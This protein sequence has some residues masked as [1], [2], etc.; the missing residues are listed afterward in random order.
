[1]TFYLSYMF[2]AERFTNWC[3]HVSQNAFHKISTKTLLEEYNLMHFYTTFLTK[4]LLSNLVG[5]GEVHL[6]S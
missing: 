3:S 5:L 4:A 2:V 6:N 1:M